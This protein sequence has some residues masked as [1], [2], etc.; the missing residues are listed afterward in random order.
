MRHAALALSILTVLV[1]MPGWAGPLEDGRRLI[2]A[3]NHAQAIPLLQAAAKANPDDP[4]PHDLLAQA[5]EATFQIDAA[6]SAGQRALTIRK[7]L[8]AAANVPQVQPVTEESLPPVYVR[9]GP[10]KRL[11]AVTNQ[12]LT[13]TP[14]NWKATPID[15]P[16]KPAA[17]GSDAIAKP[18]A[19]PTPSPTP[20]PSATPAPN[21]QSI[22][23]SNPL[24]Y[25]PNALEPIQ[26]PG[27]PQ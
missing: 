4:T 14:M 24:P 15:L 11:P 26:P 19:R 25:D 10:R 20:T 13:K 6:L 21:F 7:R 27:L 3:G 1:A 2:K 5:Y 8:A 17:V 18:A 16:A 9:P 23:E 12:S 22:T